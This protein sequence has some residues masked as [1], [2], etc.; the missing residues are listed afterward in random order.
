M[1][2]TSSFNQVTIAGEEFEGV[3]AITPGGLVKVF[4]LRGMPSKSAAGTMFA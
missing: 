3:A 4:T 2:R 1:V